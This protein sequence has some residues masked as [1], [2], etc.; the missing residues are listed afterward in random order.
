MA[1]KVY[2]VGAGPGDPELITL[3]A[4]RALR[5]ADVVLYDYLANEE[6]LSYAEKAEKIYVGKSA[7]HHALEQEE[8][9]E[10]LIKKAKEGKVVVRL[11]GGDPYLFGRGGE[12]ALALAESGIEFEVV[13]GVTS[14]I[15]APSYACIPITHRKISSSLAIVTG[16]EALDKQKRIDWQNIAKIETIVILMG[17]G[18]IEEI[19]EEIIKVKGDAPIAFVYKGTTKEQRV[20]VGKLSEVKELRKKVSPPCVIIIGEVVKLR[21]KLCQKK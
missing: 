7:K 16:H 1:G 9:N 20:V 6:L 15:A 21:E 8:I 12:E 19:A 4:V 10:L 3:K 2:L 14:A 11:K 18:R 13:P 5:E 17:V